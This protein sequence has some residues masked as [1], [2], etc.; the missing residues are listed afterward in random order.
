MDHRQCLW[1]AGGYGIS[2]YHPLVS[3]LQKLDFV[4]RVYVCICLVLHVNVPAMGNSNSITE[5]SP[6]GYILQIWTMDP[7]E[8]SQYECKVHLVGGFLLLA[9]L[10]FEVSWLHLKLALP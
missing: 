9:V 5:C 10:G 7:K 2:V 3:A 6:L 8:L 4:L 1:W